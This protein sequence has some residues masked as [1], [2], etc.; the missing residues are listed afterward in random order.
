[1]KVKNG[2]KKNIA[3]ET[4][5]M[6]KTDKPLSADLQRKMNAYWRAV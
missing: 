5:K 2:V 6:D 1:M 3:V 4:E